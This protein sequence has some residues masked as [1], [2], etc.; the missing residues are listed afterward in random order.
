MDTYMYLQRRVRGSIR[1]LFRLSEDSLLIPFDALRTAALEAAA[2]TTTS[3]VPSRVYIL[4]VREEAEAGARTC[5]EAHDRAADTWKCQRSP[6]SSAM[7]GSRCSGIG[8]QLGFN[9]Y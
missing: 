6:R 3:L 4:Y 1:G 5:H 7:R 9:F 8:H 2:F